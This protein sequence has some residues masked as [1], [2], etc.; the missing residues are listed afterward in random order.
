MEK[1]IYTA[2]ARAGSAYWWNQGRQYLLTRMWRRFGRPLPGHTPRILDIGCAAGGTLSYLAAWGEAWG[3]DLSAEAVA[4]CLAWGID[5]HRLVVGDA[6]SMPFFTDERFD[7]ITAVEVLEHLPQP[8]RGLAEIRRIL[9]PGGLLLL[10]V[11]A[12]PKLW[13]DRDARLGHFRRYRLAELK[14]AV[15]AAGFEILTASYANAFYYW[16]YR[17]L[18]ALRR[19]RQG[20]SVPRVATDTL[21]APAWLSA[22]FRLLLQ[23]E[24]HILLRTGLPWGV[25]AVCAARKV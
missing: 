18:L 15:R 11:P 12:D 13:S 5:E 2:L 6:Q 16:P 7:L 19:W 22:L 9:K 23:A 20:G 3:L 21:E 1:Q 17:G 4:L 10:T 24:T 8:E 25:S 14:A